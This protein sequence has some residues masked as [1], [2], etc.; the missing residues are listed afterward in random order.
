M[1]RWSCTRCTLNATIV[2]L[3]RNRRDMASPVAPLSVADLEVDALR[4]RVQLGAREVRLSPTEHVILYTLVSRAGEVVTYRE[5]GSALG[6]AEAEIHSNRIA[7]HVST[8][9]RKLR[10]DPDHPH[11]IETVV[12]IGYEMKTSPAVGRSG[13]TSRLNGT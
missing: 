1:T 3:P 9:R 8:L 7:R 13:T 6:L 4:Q 11:Y 12:G 2:T 10:D 5:L